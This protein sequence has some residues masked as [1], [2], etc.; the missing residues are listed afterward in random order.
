[1][2]DAV[3]IPYPENRQ[4][5]PSMSDRLPEWHLRAACRGLDSNIF[6]RKQGESMRQVKAICAGC[7]VR[8]ECLD[9]AIEHNYKF[10]IWG[11]LSEKARRAIRAERGLMERSPFA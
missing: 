5:T 4:D 9:E 6:F 8:R 11:G 1:M 7:A 3:L 2:T 10:G